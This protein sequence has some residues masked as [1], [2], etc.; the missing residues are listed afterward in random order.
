MPTIRTKLGT[1]QLS[2]TFDASSNFT[3][4]NPFTG[5]PDTLPAAYV[6]ARFDVVDAFNIPQALKDALE[7]ET[8]TLVQLNKIVKAI[9]KR[10]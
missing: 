1:A 2:G 7:A 4:T 9:L 8:A 10:L 5:E 3:F 6:A